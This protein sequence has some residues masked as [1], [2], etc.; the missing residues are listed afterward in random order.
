[1]K[2]NVLLGQDVSA[3][4]DFDL[5][6]PDDATKEEVVR[7]IVEYTNTN[8]SELVFDEDWS[9]A[10]GLR[11]VA[12]M[13]G[14]EQIIGHVDIDRI[15]SGDNARFVASFLSLLGA[16]ESCINQIEQMRGLFDDSDG[17]IQAALD[18]ARGALAAARGDGGEI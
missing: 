9:T 12:A 18:D 11:I 4:A 15:M 8:I 17:A 6:V 3:Y 16:L 10:N 7:R 5:E 13:N 14:N 1:M 2:L